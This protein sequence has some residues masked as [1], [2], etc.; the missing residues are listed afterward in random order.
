MT[1]AALPAHKLK[2]RPISVSWLLRQRLERETGC[3]VT[4]KKRKV[5]A[6]DAKSAKVFHHDGTTSTT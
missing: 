1:H 2:P 3:V 4:E 6:K 5:T